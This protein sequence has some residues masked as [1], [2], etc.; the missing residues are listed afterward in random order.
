MA[1][2]RIT[3]PATPVAPGGRRAPRCSSFRLI[4][5]GKPVPFYVTGRAKYNGPGIDDVLNL[6]GTGPELLQQDWAETNWMPDSRSGYYIFTLYQ[7]RGIYGY[8]ADGRHGTRSFRSR[9]VGSAGGHAPRASLSSGPSAGIAG[10][11]PK[12]S[13]IRRSCPRPELRWLPAP[14]REISA[15]P[16]TLSADFQ[17]TL[18]GIRRWPNSGLCSA[19]ILWA[20]T[21]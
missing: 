3:L 6:D 16:G 17:A 19:S 5:R 18:T 10:R 2:A 12:R 4:N 15:D 9:E 14:W 8:R 13:P 11:L 20:T 1:V 21:E 7:Q